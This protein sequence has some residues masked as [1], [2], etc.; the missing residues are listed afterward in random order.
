[1]TGYEITIDES[2]NRL[3]MRLEGMLDEETARNVVEEIDEGTAKLDEGF[4]IVNDISE[5]KPMSQDAAD[6]IDRGKAIAAQRGANATVRVTGESVIGK[7]QFERHGQG[8]ET[9][10]V[11]TA[12]SVEEAEDLLEDFND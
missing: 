6:E 4:D 7:M 1:M 10:H 9:Y 3:Y 2:T 12:E 5:F 8:E 11:A